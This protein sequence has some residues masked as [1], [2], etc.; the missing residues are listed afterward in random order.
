MQIK[1]WGVRGSIASGS[2][3]TSGIGGNTTCVEVRCGD[4]LIII[5]TGTGV[6]DLGMA[7]M[8]EMP[9]KA[10]ILFSH[11]HWDH[12]QGFPFFGP[13]FIP[14]NEF[15]VFGGTSLPTTIKEVL[16]QQ[17]APPY[18]PV[19]TDLF[20]SKITY[21]DVK[22]GDVI[23]GNSYKVTLAPLLHPNG[24]YAY[25]ID[26][27]GKTMVFSTDCEHYED[28][29]N[30]NLIELSKDADVLIYD[31]QYTEDEYYGLNGQFSRKGWGHSTMQEGV[32]VAKA[33]NVK[34]LVLF[35]HDPSHD[36]NFI[37]QIEAE[38][39]QFFPESIAAYEGLQIDLS[40]EAFLKSFFD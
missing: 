9:L 25:R 27:Q 6:R 37:K 38:S 5:D 30:K 8:K 21:H 10:T 17:M 20:G 19:K 14:G 7:L 39:R 1:F 32:K 13:F 28:R 35:H 33:A 4:E 12:I 18:F 3:T 40:Q 36:D 22:P 11:V 31:A 15:R 24:C 34:K 2:P 29:P 26:Y 23:E 16:N